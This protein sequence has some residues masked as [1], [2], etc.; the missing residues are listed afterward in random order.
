MG[1]GGWWQAKKQGDDLKESYTAAVLAVIIEIILKGVE[2]IVMVIG[3]V[4][5]ILIVMVMVI[6]IVIIK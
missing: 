3:V 4:A 1:V 2:V 5:L 6:A